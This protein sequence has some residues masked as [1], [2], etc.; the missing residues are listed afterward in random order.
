MEILIT[1]E[2]I[3]DAKKK[4]KSKFIL[5]RS[6]TKNEENHFA[7]FVGE[8]LFHKQYPTAIYEGYSPDFFL[9]N[10]KIEIKTAGTNYTP[11]PFWQKAIPQ[12]EIDNHDFDYI[13]IV[14][15]MLDLSKGWLVGY[16]DRQSFM[17]KTF[18][19]YPGDIPE[20]GAEKYIRGGYTIR[21]DQLIPF[22][23]H[24]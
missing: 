22:P 6:F 11:K 12:E 3:Q 10:K 18:F 13:V 15:V 7:G 20:S 19:T 5:D 8:A 4:Q 9:K 21:F 14:S 24:Q 16:L 23:N 17:D 2:I 1:E